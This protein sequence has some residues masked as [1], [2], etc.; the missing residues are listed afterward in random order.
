MT[1]PP[2]PR[3]RDRGP[4]EASLP[5]STRAS[6]SEFRDHVIAAPLKLPGEHDAHYLAHEFRDHVIAAPLKL[7]TLEAEETRGFNSAIT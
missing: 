1:A 5:R 3:S 6:L 4:I 2:I 7:H